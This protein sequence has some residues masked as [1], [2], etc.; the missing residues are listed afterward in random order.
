VAHL[1]GGVYCEEIVEGYEEFASTGQGLGSSKQYLVPWTSRY[2]VANTLLGF[3]YRAPLLHPE[4]LNMRAMSVS[5]RGVG[6]PTQGPI[7]LAFPYA[8]LRVDWGVPTWEAL[9]TDDPGNQMGMDPDTPLIYATQRM[10]MSYQM[11]SIPGRAVQ[12]SSGVKM[13]D[14]FYGYKIVN[15]EMILTL[16]QLQN[17]PAVNYRSLMGKINSSTFLGGA[18]GKVRFDN[19]ETARTAST[20]GSRTQEVTM[21]FTHRDIARWDYELEPDSGAWLQIQYAT[22]ANAGLPLIQSAD[23]NQL[24]P[25]QYRG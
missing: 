12:F 3:N 14:T 16:H 8:I 5:I 23:L 20:D 18:I 15:T 22:G 4:S 2:L 7:Q 10:S 21:Y 9:R 17:L 11:V 6:A 19:L 13:K 1:I 25:A 24:I